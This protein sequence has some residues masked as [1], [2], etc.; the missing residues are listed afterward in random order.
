MSS[1]AADLDWSVIQTNR[2]P[3][4][5]TQVVCSLPHSAYLKMNQSV[6]RM[7]DVIAFYT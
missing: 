7:T 1:G 2:S 5:G 6:N 4:I 3:P